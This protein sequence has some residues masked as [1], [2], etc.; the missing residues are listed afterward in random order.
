MHGILAIT[1]FDLHKTD[2]GAH[3]VI[4][5][6]VVVSG[7]EVQVHVLDTGYVQGAA[8]GLVDLHSQE[9]VAGGRDRIYFD[10][11]IGVGKRGVQQVGAASTLQHV[12]A[13]TVGPVDGVGAVAGRHL[14]VSGVAGGNIVPRAGG[15]DVV[16]G[17]AVNVIVAG[18]T[19]DHVV[20]G[21]AINTVGAVA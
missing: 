21:I 4:D 3:Q 13:V 8:T 7:R 2:L 12:I 18:T 16:P 17:V 19:G 5:R 15:Q 6:D 9:V 10:R 20:T 14:V 1:Q 11:I